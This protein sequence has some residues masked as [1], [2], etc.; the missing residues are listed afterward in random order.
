MLRYRRRQGRL[1][2]INMTYRT[3][4]YMRLGSLKLLLRHRNFTPLVSGLSCT[5]ASRSKQSLTRH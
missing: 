5:D 4:I 3:H 1:A 2:M